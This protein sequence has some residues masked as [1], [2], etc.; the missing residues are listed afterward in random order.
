MKNLKFKK[1]LV[2]AIT[3]SFLIFSYGSFAQEKKKTLEISTPDFEQ[4]SIRYK[5]GNEKYRYRISS[6]T[7]NNKSLKLD[8]LEAIKYLNF[9]LGLG[10]EFHKQL[11]DKLSFL[12]GPQLSGSIGN[13]KHESDNSLKYGI[14]LSCILGFAYHFNTAIHLGA[15]ILPGFSYYQ[16]NDENQSFENSFQFNFSNYPAAIVLGFDF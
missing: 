16:N 12:Y 15:E 5:F 6:F 2:F 9:G 3:T 13:T 1:I 7:L 8:S 4:F 11:N 10:V 14:S